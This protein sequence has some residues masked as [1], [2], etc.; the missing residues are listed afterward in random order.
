MTSSARDA[1]FEMFV[2]AFP[3]SKPWPHRP[4]R[5]CGPATTP[6][7]STVPRRP[8]TGCEPTRWAALTPSGCWTRRSERPPR[9]GVV[10]RRR[11][12]DRLGCRSPRDRRGT[13]HRRT[14]PGAGSR[15]PL[16]PGAPISRRS[17]GRSRRLRGARS[18]HRSTTDRDRRRLR[19]R[20]PRDWCARSPPAIEGCRPPLPQSALSPLVDWTGT[21]AS[22]RTNADLDPIVSASGFRRARESYLDG[23]DLRD[24]LASPLFGNLRGLPPLQIH[25]G[26]DETLYDDAVSLA[27]RADGRPRRR[28]SPCCTRHVSPL[29]AV[30]QRP[31]RRTDRP[32]RDRR[33]RVHP[34]DASPRVAR[35]SRLAA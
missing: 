29:A 13:V 22:H 10:S 14:L 24:P 28:R 20:G 18:G 26:T 35:S 12:H 21:S 17:R 9:L 33:L 19:R 5:T 7:C 34:P 4:S 16:G 3:I 27:E 2:A 30:R 8:R 23:H 11:V 1:A 6:C 32:G 25:I 15:V 31:R